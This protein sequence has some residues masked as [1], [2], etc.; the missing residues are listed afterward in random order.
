MSPNVSPSCSP[1]RNAGICA[2]HVQDAERPLPDVRADPLVEEGD[3]RGVQQVQACLGARL[4]GARL[5]RVPCAKTCAHMDTS[6]RLRLIQSMQSRHRS[7]SVDRAQSSSGS[8]AGT[9]RRQGHDPLR[10]AAQQS[11]PRSRALTSTRGALTSATLPPSYLNLFRRRSRCAPL[12][13]TP[14]A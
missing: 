14:W 1:P 4:G 6:L 7:P 5:G 8:R 2:T 9:C 3:A 11:T 13:H 12:A 10:C